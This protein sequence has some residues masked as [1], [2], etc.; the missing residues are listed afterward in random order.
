MGTITV[1][2]GAGVAV[3][4]I[5][6]YNGGTG[7]YEY[8]AYYSTTTFSNN[9]TSRYIEVTYVGAASG[10]TNATSSRY[11]AV[12]FNSGSQ[13]IYLSATQ[14]PPT[15]TVSYNANGGT[16]APGSQS[17][18][19]EGYRTITSSIPTRSGYTFIGWNESS[20]AVTAAV[21]A[22]GSYYVDSSFTFYAVWRKNVTLTYNANNGTGAPS[23][24]THY[25]GTNGKYTFTISYT[26][27]TRSGYNFTGWWTSE[28]TGP[29]WG[30]DTLVLS[31]NQTLYAG[32]TISTYNVYGYIST[33]VSS[34]TISYTAANG[35]SVSKT[36]NS[37]NSGTSVAIKAGTSI[38]FSSCTL[39]DSTYYTNPI[40]NFCTDIDYPD[41]TSVAT[42]SASSSFTSHAINRSQNIQLKASIIQ[43][44]LSFDANGGT[45]PPSSITQNIRTEF[46][47]PLKVPTKS[48]YT[49]N[50]W[51]VY[52]DGET[53]YWGNNKI[54]L[55]KNT[56][57]KAAWRV[58][59]YN[60]YFWCS[61]PVTSYSVTYTPANGNAVTRTINLLNSGISYEIKYN[62]TILFNSVTYNPGYENPIAK[63]YAD[64]DYPSV[65]IASYDASSSFTSHAITQ[66]QN[67]RID[68][69]HITISLFSWHDDGDASYFQSGLP[70]QD[71]L[72][73]A[74]WNSI[75]QKIIDV[76]KAYQQ[77]VPLLV[78][79]SSGDEITAAEFNNVRVQISN[80]EN[81]GT[82]PGAVSPGDTILP[83]MFNGPGSLKAALN[84]SIM[85]LNGI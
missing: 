37:S 12:Y 11:G 14:V 54:T 13:S 73:A 82:L 74:A 62:T 24:E 64:A 58:T 29:F 40:A 25:V 56:V 61:S 46:T 1:Y 26:I 49:F 85:A 21:T 59:T 67:M 77:N 28:G 69:T 52:P 53:P 65:L 70:V 55:T 79:V 71:A 20:S 31:A 27:P 63:F 17:W 72:T 36:F 38:S 10:Y 43:V 42:Y 48:G 84:A 4:T 50:G 2:F 76:R 35:N 7:K 39:S 19:G 75:K 30:G 44:T 60:V 80:T 3:A 51:Y 57:M 68:V 6:S 78:T 41:S 47:I 32:W 66:S 81:S 22:G 33:G 83:G 45:N 8:N 9:N 16:G 5:A 18:Q 23:S 34:F 15:Y